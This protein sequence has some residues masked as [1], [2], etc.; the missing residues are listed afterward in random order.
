MPYLI[1]VITCSA[2]CWKPFGHQLF[3]LYLLVTVRSSDSLLCM[4]NLCSMSFGLQLCSASVCPVF[5]L[6]LLYTVQP[7]TNTYHSNCHFLNHSLKRRDLERL[8]YK[9]L[10]YCAWME[11]MKKTMVDE[12]N[13]CANYRGVKKNSA[14]LIRLPP[15]TCIW[16]HVRCISMV[17]ECHELAGGACEVVSVIN[18]N[19]DFEF[20]L[21]HPWIFSVK[22]FVSHQG[23][24]EED[25]VD[26]VDGLRNGIN[27][28]KW[29][30]QAVHVITS[31]A[32]QSKECD[33]LVY[34]RLLD[35]SEF[36]LE[37]SPSYHRE[38]QLA[39]QKRGK[40]QGEGPNNSEA[41]GTVMAS[42][43]PYHM[44]TTMELIDSCKKCKTSRWKP[45]KRNTIGDDVVVNKR[46][47]I[48]TKRMFLSSKIAE[49]MRWHA[50]ESTIEGMLSHPRDS[51]AWKKFDLMHLQ[52]ALDPR[53][54]R[55]GL[56]TNGFNPYG[57]LNTNHNIWPFVLIPLTALTVRKGG[58]GSKPINLV[59]PAGSKRDTIARME[60]DTEGRL[61]AI[62]ITM[63]GMKAGSAVVRRDLQQIMQILGTNANNMEGHSDDGFV[64]DNQ[65][66]RV[67]EVGGRGV[68][69]ICEEQRPWRKRVE[70]PTFDGVVSDEEKVE[71]AYI[72]MEGSAT[73]WFTFWKEKAKS[74]SWEGLKATMVNRFGGGFRGTVFVRLQVLGYFLAGLC[75][76]IKGQE[77]MAAMRIARDV[78]DAMIR[79]KGG[80]ESGFKINPSVS[81]S[82]RIM[83][84]SEVNRPPMNQYKG[85]ESM[86]FSRR[87]GVAANTN[88]RAS[89]SMGNENRGRMVKNLPYLEFL[90]RKEEGRCFRCRGLFAPGHRCAKRSLQVL[91]LAEDEEGE[92]K[93][94]ELL[95]CSAEG[96]TSPKTMKLIG[97][98]GERRVVVLIDSGASHNYISR[99]ITE[100]LKLPITDT[101]LVSLE[102]AIV[103]EEFYGFELGGV[104]VILGVAW[105]AKLGELEEPKTLLKL[106]DTESWWRK[107]RTVEKEENSEW[108]DD[109]TKAHTI[110]YFERCKAYPHLMTRSTESHSR[111]ESSTSPFS[112]PVILVKKKDDNWC[113][114]VDYRALN[115]ATVPD[116]FPI[117][118]AK[119]SS[120]IDLKAG[121]HQIRM[122]EDV[123]KTAFRTHQGHFE[124]LV[125]PFALTNVSATFQSTMNSLLQQYLRKC[126]LLFFDDILVYSPT[127]KDHLEQLKLVLQLLDEFGKQRICYLGHQISER[128]V[129][130]DS[131]K[132]KAV[133][134]WEEPKMKEVS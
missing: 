41:V 65:Q 87:D 38:C 77:L 128:G 53:N 123:P 39:D 60:R 85:T 48:P 133:L 44:P 14:K 18:F 104:D 116:K 93:P 96:L 131:D 58:N 89:T 73:Y 76:D 92:E 115:R 56:A 83:I 86:G 50:S 121:Y 70:L 5:D 7:L 112:S 90:K 97:K 23:K 126:V 64:N 13:D 6:E 79:A 27:N 45:K 106:A 32:P 69:D 52:F 105:L 12:D 78:E 129:E 95:A 114:C 107:R 109:L 15:R 28:R 30:R 22:P 101:P 127:W 72:S 2:C 19:L 33:T 66:R 75:E 40:S 88:A 84:R 42:L 46:K 43:T 82:A 25:I 17:E 1:S 24:L 120:K 16:L 111:K 132:M 68:S 49:H 4:F 61:E 125:M 118:G 113:F 74:R 10:I 11:E 36:L 55:L 54:V 34:H 98:I 63:E 108:D 110:V 124:F 102:E 99:R 20:S 57:N 71:I 119:Y 103:K 35:M 47:K 29:K 134:E 26:E 91:L 37:F 100:E 59:R 62:E 81:R 80:Y 31:R 51:E 122:G 9:C 3:G 21:L 130:M 94:L 8:L 117:S 67:G